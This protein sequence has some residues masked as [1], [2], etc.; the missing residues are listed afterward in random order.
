[1]HVLLAFLALTLYLCEV[2]TLFSQ[3]F[4]SCLDFHEA[5]LI[6][7]FTFCSNIFSLG[8]STSTQTHKTGHC[9]TFLL[10]DTTLAALLQTVGAAGDGFSCDVMRQGVPFSSLLEQ[11]QNPC[12]VC[13]NKILH[14]TDL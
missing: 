12:W 5:D 1:M 4:L 2:D 11:T 8:I 6:V 10:L 14:K 7:T 3:L 13:P 9:G